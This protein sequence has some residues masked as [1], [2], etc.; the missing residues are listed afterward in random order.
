MRKLVGFI[1]DNR[2]WFS[3]FIALTLSISL[4][5]NNDSPNI[6]ILRGKINSV[7]SI[8]F[9]PANWV[10]GI[11]ILKEEN[12]TLK[13]KVLQLSLLNSKLLHYKD[14]NERLRNMLAYKD[15]TTL[16]LIPGRVTSTGLSPLITA[17]TINVGPG[18]DLRPN[19]AV[20]NVDGVV[21][22]TI[23]VGPETA[24]VQLMTDYSFR[25][26]VKI[27][28]SETVGILRWHDGNNFQVWEI[29][30]A[31]KV[32]VGDRIVTSG[33]SD[34]FPPDLPVGSVSDVIVRSDMLQKIAVGSAYAD[35][36]T[37]GHVFVVK[38]ASD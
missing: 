3:I 4:L 16:T 21:G 27:A 17:V 33:Y 7:M 13:Y 8:L 23:S 29:P 22:K 10:K 24:V 25:L 15:A 5:S 37:I 20:I 2:D 36:T 6:Q 9:A 32:N 18:H 31:T 30:Q 26:S 38:D 34:I 11:G 1:L 14:D 28:R 12:A 35:F 19:L